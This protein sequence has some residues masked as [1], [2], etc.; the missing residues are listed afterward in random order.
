[1]TRD[2]DPREKMA[3]QLLMRGH[4]TMD[5]ILA[6]NYG[7]WPPKGL[8]IIGKNTQRVKLVSL[9]DEESGET[10]FR[11]LWEK[12]L[13]ALTVAG[14]STLDRDREIRINRFVCGM[15][16]APFG[17][18]LNTIMGHEAAHILQGDHY[19]RAYKLFNREDSHAIYAGQKGI[20]ADNIARPL[21]DEHMKTGRLRAMFNKAAKYIYDDIDYQKQGTEI[22][23]RLHEILITGYPAWG[24][25]PGSPAELMTA[26]RDAGLSM[27]AALQ[28]ELDAAPGSAEIRATFSGAQQ[29]GP[30]PP[31]LSF[32]QSTLTDEGK[33]RLWRETLPAL[34]ADLI[35]MYGDG[36]GRARMGLGVNERAAYR[37][38]SVHFNPRPADAA[39]AG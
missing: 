38:R 16:P 18:S 30:L 32:M 29:H 33:T 26:L 4:A 6:A 37:E 20:K 36:P 22:Q 13:N 10:G 12:T 24:R 23:A 39:S 3:Y 35:E 25:L 31:G 14:S 9:L 11:R 1:M 19:W 8:D 17:E 27:P 15:L 7:E 34:Y 28:E 2:R 21:F 5:E